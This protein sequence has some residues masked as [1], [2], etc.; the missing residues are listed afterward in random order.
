MRDQ[1]SFQYKTA[2]K[3]IVPYVRFEVFMAVKI[4]VKVFWVVTPCSDER[5]LPHHNTAS[6]P[7]RPQL[8]YF[9][10]F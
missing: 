8:I 3:V 5:Y 10:V 9:Y 6:Q 1:V 2:G 4:P 7:R